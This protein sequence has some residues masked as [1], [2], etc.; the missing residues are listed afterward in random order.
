MH[1]YMQK[2]KTTKIRGLA[3]VAFASL[4]GASVAHGQLY[5]SDFT[6][7]DGALPTDWSAKFNSDEPTSETGLFNDTFRIREE[8]NSQ[9]PAFRT[10]ELDGTVNG[11]ASRSDYTVTTEF[12]FDSGAATTNAIVYGRSSGAT[13]TG[14][15]ATIDGYQLN[16]T[17]ASTNELFLG[18]GVGGGSTGIDNSTELDSA[19]I[20]DSLTDG[21]TYT[22]QLVLDGTSISG[23]LFDGAGTT[24]TVLGSVSGTDSTFTSGSFGLGAG[25]SALGDHDV[26]YD[27]IS[28]LPE[29]GTFALLAGIAALTG[30]MLRRRRS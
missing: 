1:Q 29:P 22:L 2:T 3:I 13:T 9:F 4:L 10:F 19:T 30:V 18:A 8:T 7:N 12:Q 27:N 11:F 28:A 16:I 5:Q 25:Y 21:D 20:T 14:G 23:T 6:G 24:G 15:N 17:R 26:N